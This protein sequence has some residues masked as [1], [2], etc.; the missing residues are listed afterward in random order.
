[1]LGTISISLPR[2]DTGEV[3]N[4]PNLSVLEVFG[5][6]PQQHGLTFAQPCFGQAAGLED[7]QRSLPNEI[8]YF[9]PTE[10]RITVERSIGLLYYFHLCDNT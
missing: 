3:T 9:I 7:C 2:L 10:S 8:F 1:M 4:A 6:C 5:Q